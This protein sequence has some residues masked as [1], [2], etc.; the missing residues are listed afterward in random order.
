MKDTKIRPDRK[1]MPVKGGF[2]IVAVHSCRIHSSESGLFQAK[3]RQEAEY[4]SW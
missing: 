3:L 2:W 1:D 4:Q